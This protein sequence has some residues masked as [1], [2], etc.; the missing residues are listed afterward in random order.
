MRAVTTA[1]AAAVLGLDRKA[2]DSLLV[3][4]G[5]DVLPQGRQGLERRIPVGL[6]EVLALTSDISAAINIPAR[7]AFAFAQLLI[8]HEDLSA[9]AHGSRASDGS[10][11]AIRRRPGGTSIGTFLTVDADLSALRQ[12]IDERLEMAIESVVRPA[13]GRPRLT[14]TR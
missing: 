12:A 11:G 7:Q 5:T 14:A 6:L 3:R 10:S 2:L 9:P 13:R 4:L 8:A 1:T